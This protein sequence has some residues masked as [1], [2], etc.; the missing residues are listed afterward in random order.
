MCRDNSCK[1]I[2]SSAK[3]FTSFVP[4]YNS[5]LFGEK[6]GTANVTLSDSTLAEEIC[7]LFDEVSLLQLC[8]IF[9]G[10]QCSDLIEELLQLSSL[11]HVTN[12]LLTEIKKDFY[13]CNMSVFVKEMKLFL[14]EK[15][16]I[17]GEK[18]K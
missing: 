14:A 11:A 8:S 3:V 13:N 15:V 5:K 7:E 17:V 1:M 9:Y 12:I 10:F 4:I 6:L 18:A 2:L 16:W